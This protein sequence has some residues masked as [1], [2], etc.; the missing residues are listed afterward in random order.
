MYKVLFIGNSRCDEEGCLA[1]VDGTTTFAFM[2]GGVTHADVDALEARMYVTV[3]EVV[4]AVVG[5]LQGVP[6]PGRVMNCLDSA[7][8]HF[9]LLKVC[10][11]CARRRGAG[12]PRVRLC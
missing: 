4:C 3:S 2:L 7:M 9:R 5:H 1:L 6:R 8:Q 12:S 11:G 10:I